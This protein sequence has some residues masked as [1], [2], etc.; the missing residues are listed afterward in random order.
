MFNVWVRVAFEESFVD[1]G[2]NG[3]QIMKEMPSL[4]AQVETRYDTVCSKE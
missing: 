3:L 4:F 1:A 2:D